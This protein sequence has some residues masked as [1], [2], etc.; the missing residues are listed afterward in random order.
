MDFSPYRSFFVYRI[1]RRTDA[2][3]VTEETVVEGDKIAVSCWMGFTFYLEGMK[4]G[5]GDNILESAFVLRRFFYGEASVFPDKKNLFFE[6]FPLLFSI[7][8]ATI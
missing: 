1:R 5:F 4:N 2:S 3:E 7:N 6:L 8:I